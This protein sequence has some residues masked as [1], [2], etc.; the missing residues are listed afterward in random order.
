MHVQGRI[1][2]NL[3][4]SE[5]F[6]PH[7]TS[8][9]ARDLLDIVVEADCQIEFAGSI[10]V[11]QGIP[12][13]YQGTVRSSARKIIAGNFSGSRNLIP[14]TFHSTPW[15]FLRNSQLTNGISPFHCGNCSGSQVPFLRPTP[16][17][18]LSW[19]CEVLSIS[20][21]SQVVQ[22]RETLPAL[23]YRSRAV[24]ASN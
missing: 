10:G 11:C 20:R 9:Q 1:A 18:S 16:G 15:L 24:G 17:R 7:N 14:G 2:I 23:S 8:I 22:T 21:G 6:V 5:D 19:K 3:P 12:A 4:F 13:R